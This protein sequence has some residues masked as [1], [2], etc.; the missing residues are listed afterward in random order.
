MKKKPKQK[1]KKTNFSLHLNQALKSRSLAFFGSWSKP[2]HNMVVP[3]KIPFRQ[4]T[5][6]IYLFIY[7]GDVIHF[8]RP[9]VE[10]HLAEFFITTDFFS[11]LVPR[12]FF[13]SLLYY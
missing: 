2:R 13:V 6:I 7:S 1:N 10:F 9:L 4:L 5:I 8:C 3:L 11:D 12:I